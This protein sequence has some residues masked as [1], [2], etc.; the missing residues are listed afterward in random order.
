MAL[1]PKGLFAAGNVIQFSVDASTTNPAAT[2]TQQGPGLVMV[3][4]TV[5]SLDAGGPFSFQVAVTAPGG[6]QDGAGHR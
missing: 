4:F 3:I 5:T 6:K 1:A 2:V